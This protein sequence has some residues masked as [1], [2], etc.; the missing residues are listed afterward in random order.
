MFARAVLFVFA[1][2]L[3]WVLLTLLGGL[4][5]EATRG[6]LGIL[7]IHSDGHGSVFNG[8]PEFLSV[9]TEGLLVSLL[10]LVVTA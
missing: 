10:A 6:Q 8:L 1:C 2:L 7:T 9:E 5:N 4:G 3:I